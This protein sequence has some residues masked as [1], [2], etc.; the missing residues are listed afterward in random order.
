MHTRESN[1]LQIKKTPTKRKETT[2]RNMQLWTNME[3]RLTHSSST[4]DPFIIAITMSLTTQPRKGQAIKALDKN[5]CNCT[6]AAPA[7][8]GAILGPQGLDTVLS[9]CCVN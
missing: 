3:C 8:L 5:D 4:A 7:L 9:A 1:M 2:T 6:K